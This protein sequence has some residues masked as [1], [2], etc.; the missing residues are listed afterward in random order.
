M[1]NTRDKLNEA[2]FFLEKMNRT[3]SDP[4]SFRYL[5]TAFLATG[6]SVEQIMKEEF[7]GKL[8][9]SDWHAQKLIEMKND[10]TL[11]YLF[12][13]RN[14][15]QHERPVLQYPIDVVNQTS[16]GSE[17]SVFLSGTGT[18]L[19][20]SIHLMDSLSKHITTSAKYY[21]I[22]IPDKGKDILTLCQ[23]AIDTIESIVK[24]CE[25]KFFGN[26]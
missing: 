19:S 20:A 12:K 16:D 10:P 24:E 13:Q 22:D 1:T 25:S 15:T 9:F 17:I 3:L 6:R 4:T 18:D 11:K 5:L 23:E 21:F 8:G 26:L 14:I 7:A 2:K